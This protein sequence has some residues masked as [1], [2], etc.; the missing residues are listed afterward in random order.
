MIPAQYRK[1]GFQPAPYRKKP[2]CLSCLRAPSPQ[3]FFPSSKT[4]NKP[5]EKKKKKGSQG[6][7]EE[8]SGA[9]G[10]CGSFG[11]FPVRCW[12]EA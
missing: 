4:T 5:P 2:S 6:K 8:R 10:N 3:D 11:F 7:K 12:L 1:L 9:E